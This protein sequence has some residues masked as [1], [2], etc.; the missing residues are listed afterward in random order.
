MKNNEFKQEF[1][2]KPKNLNVQRYKKESVNEGNSLKVKRKPSKEKK[3]NS[4]DKKEQNRKKKSSLCKNK[5]K[6]YVAQINEKIYKK[7]EARLQ[8]SP[9]QDN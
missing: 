5:S 9:L 8:G 6:N 2:I 3:D 7:N 4:V 1:V